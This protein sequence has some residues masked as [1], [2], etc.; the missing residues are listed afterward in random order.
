LLLLAGS[1]DQMWP[2][3]D[4]ANRM[5]D[6]RARAEDRLLTYPGAGHFLRPPVTPT[7]VPWSATLFSGGTPAGTARAQAG[8]WQA[9][10]DFLALHVA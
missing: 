6:R 10:L 4:M 1:D 2:S 7:T 9:V 8:A 3:E 5:L